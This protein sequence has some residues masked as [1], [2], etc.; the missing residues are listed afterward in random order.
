M[1]TEPQHGSIQA[2]GWKNPQSWGSKDRQKQQQ[3]Y[4][5]YR[6]SPLFIGCYGHYGLQHVVFLYVA[7]LYLVVFDSSFIQPLICENPENLG[8]VNE[9]HLDK[10]T[11]GFFVLGCPRKLGSMV[12]KWVISPTYKWGIPRGYN[13][14]IL[15]I[16]PKFL[17]HPSSPWTLSHGPLRPGPTDAFDGCHAVWR[18]VAPSLSLALEGKLGRF[19]QKSPKNVG[20]CMGVSENSGCSPPNHPWIN[21]VFHSKLNHPFWGTPIFGNT[22]NLTK[23]GWP[24]LGNQVNA[25]P[26]WPCITQW[27]TNPRSEGLCKLFRNFPSCTKISSRAAG[28]FFPGQVEHVGQYRVAVPIRHHIW[29]QTVWKCLKCSV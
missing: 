4:R 11:V 23:T 6:G 24:L 26:S 22:H 29:F 5:F 12:C 7:Q 3:T 13:P 21:R 9:P 20:K 16:D 19:L 18:A 10:S 14:L 17:V 1:K 28:A 15:T 25:S 27:S 8:K 2:Y